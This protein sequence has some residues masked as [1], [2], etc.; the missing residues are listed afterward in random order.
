MNYKSK[1][2][3]VVA[4]MSVITL[5]RFGMQSLSRD[6]DVSVLPKLDKAQ[7]TM[8]V[9][10]P[11]MGAKTFK[12][13]PVRTDAGLV[14]KGFDGSGNT[15]SYVEMGDTRLG[16]IYGAGGSY[17]IS[18]AKG[19]VHVAKVLKNMLVVSGL[20]N[21]VIR[22]KSAAV[23]ENSPYVSKAGAAEGHL[24][25][26]FLH[27][28]RVV[29]SGAYVPF[30]HAALL[31][32]ILNDTFVNSSITQARPRLVGLE[33]F[34]IN[35]SSYT[36]GD[37]SGRLNYGDTAT[38]PA[39]NEVHQRLAALREQYK[40]DLVVWQGMPTDN[41]AG[42]APSFGGVRGGKEVGD[43]A[44]VVKYNPSTAF[45]MESTMETAAHEIGHM[46]GASHDRIN[47]P[48][49]GW[50]SYS[51]GY[52]CG[53]KADLMTIGGNGSGVSFDRARLFSTPA[54]FNN[55]IACGVPI[56]QANEADNAATI[57]ESLGIITGYYPEILRV[58]TV[59]LE[60]VP[61]IVYEP[62]IGDNSA[63]RSFT[64]DVVRSGDTAAAAS[65][66]VQVFSTEDQLFIKNEG[67]EP[68]YNDNSQ[69]V[70]FG[71][72]ESRKQ[73]VVNLADD[74][75]R[76]TTDRVLHV[77]LLFPV[78]VDLGAVTDME[79]AYI[80][81]S[82]DSSA[83]SFTTNSVSVVEGNGVTVTASR[84]VPANCS[85]P[86][87]LGT[88]AFMLTSATQDAAGNFITTKQPVILKTQFDNTGRA[89]AQS[90]VVT[91]P[92]ANDSVEGGNKSF[93]ISLETPTA[94]E[95][96][97]VAVTI[98]DDEDVGLAQFDAGA[99]SGTEGASLVATVVR[100]GNTVGTL[101][102]NYA[103]RALAAGTANAAVAGSDFAPVTGSLVFAAGETSKTITVALPDD[104][105]AD[106]RKDFAIDLS[107]AD[108]G[109]PASTTASIADKGAV[110]SGGGS[111][112]G[113]TSGG[114]AGGGGGA[115]GLGLL[116]LMFLVRRRKK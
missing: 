83:W 110:T 72:G 93:T 76:F 66:R 32:D 54:V 39:F 38:D 18:G 90:F 10:L 63:A 113:G 102:V 109:S 13:L 17:S 47:D 41:P 65:V 58:G 48:T 6:A 84:P 78:G 74:G 12:V 57:R 108:I 73:V 8:S 46:L 75:N 27:D 112:G 80:D 26:L 116:P 59:S 22:R 87:Y 55:G 51:F 56:G 20:E 5:G 14:Y 97:S 28:P 36:C 69:V 105:V 71:A 79:A 25:I 23:D 111:T 91:V 29:D 43:A 94:G 115:F 35:L 77:G 42:C 49:Q 106:G 100:A 70:R 52:Q 40:A 50:K 30:A 16:M 92:T 67:S 24:D 33:P 34:N 37:A 61:A 98:V 7:A 114:S 60:G 99:L 104:G 11:G 45:N 44:A 81:K 19:S 21:D 96:K 82:H 62:G 15:L 103:V 9:V 88:G 68:Q 89:T 86:C 1:I 3:L 101:S 95:N 64:V 31:Q 53:D 2:K 85:T 107:G 4:L